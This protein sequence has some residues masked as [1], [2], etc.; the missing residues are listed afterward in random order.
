VTEARSHTVSVMGAVRR[1]GVFEVRTSK[2]VLEVLS[3]AEGLADDAGETVLIVR[4]DAAQ[5]VAE[6]RLTD[7][8]ESRDGALN[9][10]VHP[11]DTVK[12]TRQGVI[13]VV[14]DVKKPGAFAIERGRQ[15]A[16]NALA[17]SEGL[18]G[19]SS[20]K[21]MILRTNAEGD[22]DVVDVDLD[23]LMKGKLPD[24]ALQSDDVLFVPQSGAKSF[25]RAAR[26]FALIGLRIAFIW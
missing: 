11:G 25:G 17:R 9:V 10:P 2:S 3:L 6:L 8:M 26:D 19:T 21:A 14:G 13:Y 16:L 15:T 24:V 4:A 23:Q 20:K 18:T 1:P 7:L 22:R 5:P 12:V